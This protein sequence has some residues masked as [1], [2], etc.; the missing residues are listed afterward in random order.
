MDKYIDFIFVGI[1][2]FN[3]IFLIKNEITF[4]NR[5]LIIDAIHEYNSQLQPNDTDYLEKMIS[6]DS[7]ESYIK[8]LCRIWDFGCE[9]I[10]S[11]EDY[12][13]IKKYL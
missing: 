13:K 6:Y 9:N 8:T 2:I 7:M 5:I 3:I 11:E 1:T 10:V 4:K 12:N